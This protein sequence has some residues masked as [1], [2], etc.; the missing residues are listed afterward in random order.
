MHVHSAVHS[1]CAHVKHVLGNIASY[2]PSYL[3]HR[4]LPRFGLCIALPCR[5]LCSALYCIMYCIALL[6]ALHCIALHCIALH[7]IA[8]LCIDEYQHTVYEVCG[9]FCLLDSMR[10]GAPHAVFKDV[11]HAPRRYF[12]F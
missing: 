3:L 4:F 5:L 11:F 10:Y 7:C 12:H 8:L 2:G 1:V 6:N 9:L